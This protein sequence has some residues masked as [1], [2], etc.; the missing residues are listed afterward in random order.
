MVRVIIGGDVCPMGEIENSFKE[1]K[2]NEI[3]HDLLGDIFD[4]DLS[5]VN[6]ECPLVSRKTPIAKQAVLGAN[7]ECIEGFSAAK[8]DVINLANNHSFDHGPTGLQETIRI[9]KSRGINVVGAGKNL[10]EAKT[11][12]VKEVDGQR[13]VVYSM[14]EREFS[15]AD[16]YTGGA[17]PLDLI[18]FVSS[19]R[20]HKKDGI[21]IVLI[22][23][24]L[25]Y[26]PYPSPEMVRRCR[27][28][29]DMG[30]DAVICCHTHCPLPWETYAD[31]PIVYGLGNLVFEPIKES[32]KSWREGYLAKLTIENRHVLFEAIP[33]FQSNDGLGAK[34]MDKKARSK[35][36]SKMEEK[37]N[38]LKDS[39]FIEN[40]WSAYCQKLRNDY[41]SLL[42][43]YNKL[44]VKMR[45]FL[46]PLLHSK[47]AT[48]LSLLLVQCETHQEILNTLF[49]DERKKALSV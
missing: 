30:A 8:W 47:D 5:I 29:V 31:R 24:G 32:L 7:K 40:K 35:F 48:R 2:A 22:H 16:N 9:I 1:G 26:Y 23:G 43:G 19:I 15:V 6:L 17:N 21:F 33:Y 3:F 18:N 37:S 27:F 10:T 12:V 38:K 42:F 11:P 13:I 36:I 28:M 49:K 20:E 39:A 25:E 46:V 41:L 45:R 4:A 44:M 14:A 34:K